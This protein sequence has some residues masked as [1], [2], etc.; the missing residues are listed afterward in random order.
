M[1]QTSRRGRRS[2]RYSRRVASV[3]EAVEPFE[4]Q[5][6]RRRAQLVAIAAKL[7]IDAGP[8]V[9]THA[10]L[11]ER[12]GVGRTAVYRY[13][14]TRD[15]ILFAVT[16]A[17][18][19]LYSQPLTHDDVVAAVTAL[20]TATPEGMPPTVRR[21][22]ERI[23]DRGAAVRGLFRVVDESGE[24]YLYP[25][26]FFVPIALTRPVARAMRDAA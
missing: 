10:T 13:F 2:P 3:T 7:V 9:V 23:P 18:E 14:P 5:G 16:S 11:A 25:E 1:P 12:A 22:Y 6:E 19:A 8:E 4:T 15:D 21:L 20:A 26:K 17:W 24:D